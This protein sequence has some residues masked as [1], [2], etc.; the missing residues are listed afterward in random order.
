MRYEVIL[1]MKLAAST[2]YHIE[3]E[4]HP[5]SASI[6]PQQQEEVNR[7]SKIFQKNLRKIIKK[8]EDNID[9]SEIR[10]YGRGENESK[11][12]EI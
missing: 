4:I 5:L 2:S 6:L 11:C 9:K 10:W 12:S 1:S 7:K 3:K 8:M